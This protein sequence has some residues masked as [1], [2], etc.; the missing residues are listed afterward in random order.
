MNTVS[1][2]GWYVDSETSK[3]MTYEKRLRQ[4]VSRARGRISGGVG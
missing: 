4:Q 2:I 3:H 1:S